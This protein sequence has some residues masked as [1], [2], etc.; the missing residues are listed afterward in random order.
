[1]QNVILSYWLLANNKSQRALITHF[2]WCVCILSFLFHAKDG[3]A[4]L[5]RT[6][7]GSLKVTHSLFLNDVTLGLR[8][9]HAQGANQLPD[10][11]QT[12]NLLTIW[13]LQKVFPIIFPKQSRVVGEAMHFNSHNN[14]LPMTCKWEVCSFFPLISNNKRLCS[15]AECF[16][17]SLLGKDCAAAFG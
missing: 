17:S 14:T 12:Y 15:A 11:W 7:P 3:T 5:L 16:Q 8:G 6:V 4:L 1:M 9:K 2:T 13:T 10:I